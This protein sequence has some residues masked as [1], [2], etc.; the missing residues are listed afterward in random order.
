MLV[1]PF[2][3]GL[4]GVV[5]LVLGYAWPAKKIKNPRKSLKNW[6]FVFG[7]FVMLIY[8]YLNY[9][10]GG[11]IFYIFL[12]LLANLASLFLMLRI[13]KKLSII[14]ILFSSVA[15]IAASLF[16]FEDLNTVLFIVGLSLIAVGYILDS[17][18]VKR[19]TMLC[20]GSIFI[21]VFSYTEGNMIFFWLNVLCSSF[22]IYHIG[23]LSKWRLSY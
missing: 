21:A 12:Q 15:F 10:L 14:F 11:T 18:T 8:S 13:N 23:K 7:A 5:V 19:N 16:Y 6:L 9:L 4:T 22:S 3:I 1:N 20:L 17:G 2:Y